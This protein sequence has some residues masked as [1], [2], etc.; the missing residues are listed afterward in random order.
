[1]NETN[2]EEN[3]H[4]GRSQDIFRGGGKTRFPKILK[5]YSKNYVKNFEKKFSKIFKKF[6]KI[7]KK[8]LNNF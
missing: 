6:S 7:F 2:I 8:I 3:M 1:M 4:H 5:K